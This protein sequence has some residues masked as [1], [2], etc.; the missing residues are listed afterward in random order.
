LL[1]TTCQTCLVLLQLLRIEK[2]LLLLQSKAMMTK[3]KAGVML[4][5]SSIDDSDILKTFVFEIF[6]SFENEIFRLVHS[7]INR[8]FQD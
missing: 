5:L 2:W 1:R 8:K 6:K 3:M 7:L 4:V